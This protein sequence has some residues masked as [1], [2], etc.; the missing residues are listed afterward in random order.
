ML[1]VEIKGE[2]DLIRKGGSIDVKPKY[3]DGVG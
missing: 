3:P 2:E 1:A